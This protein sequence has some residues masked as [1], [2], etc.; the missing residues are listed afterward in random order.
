MYSLTTFSQI[1]DNLAALIPVYTNQ[2]GN[3]T[4]IITK[5]GKELLDKRTVAW[6]LHKIAQLYFFNVEAARDHYGSLLAKA[7]NIPLPFSLGLTMIPLPLR[8]ARVRGDKTTGFLVLEEIESIEPGKK[9]TCVTLRC[10]KQI[11]VYLSSK[12]AEQRIKE[13]K[14]V[15]QLF[16]HQFLPG[17]TLT[18]D[19]FAPGGQQL[20]AEK[21][22]MEYLART[23]VQILWHKASHL[24]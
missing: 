9:E 4:L 18:S 2:G 10:Q 14:L 15:Q 23:F 6:I 20:V 12:V 3:S 7:K 13:G 1:K 5:G 21:E 17:Y 22:E 19:T 8:K 24:K 11:P 16:T